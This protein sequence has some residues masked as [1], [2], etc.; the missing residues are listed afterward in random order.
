M[1]GTKHGLG[2]KLHPGGIL[3]FKKRMGNFTK[4]APVLQIGSMQA[5]GGAR[6]NLPMTHTGRKVLASCR[7]MSS[8]VFYH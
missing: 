2:P 4:I 7:E 8:G 3:P 1:D 5:A 6:G